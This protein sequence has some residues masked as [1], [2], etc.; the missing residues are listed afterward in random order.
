VLARLGHPRSAS[1]LN[2]PSSQ[3][4]ET[5]L[6]GGWVDTGDLGELDDGYLRIVGRKK[7]LVITAGGQNVNAA[8]IEALLREI[9]GIGHALVMGDRRPFLV[10]VLAPAPE[11]PLPADHEL[12]AAIATMNRGL[13]H[14]E[15]VLDVVRLPDPLDVE[16]G[17]LT[18]SGKPR[19][20]VIAERYETEIERCYR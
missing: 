10:A 19:R 15:Q 7:E 8:A 12:R 6:E 9:P 13:P 16:N 20:R 17:L 3:S 1:Y 11:V 14:H 18:R 2:V 5:F 4:A